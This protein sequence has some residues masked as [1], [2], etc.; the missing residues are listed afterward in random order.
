[1]RADAAVGPSRP[2]G[3]HSSAVI[4]VDADGNVVVGTHTIETLNW[5][6]GLFVGGVP[7]S[8]A[9]PTAF[10]DPG[11]ATLAQRTDPLSDTLVLQ[12]GAPRVAL[13]VYGTGLFPGDVQIL[14]A[15]LARGLDAEQA[16]LEPRVGYVAFDAQ[17][18]TLDVTRR[19]VDPRFDAGLLCELEERGFTLERSMPGYPAGFVDTGFPTLVT[20]SPGRLRGMTPDASYVHGVAAGD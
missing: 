2:G 13:A 20:M 7:L 10:D 14:D 3:S 17:R 12:D 15:V 4:V 5:G 19:S 11:A 9:G 6:E 1:V 16:V 8:T 18:M